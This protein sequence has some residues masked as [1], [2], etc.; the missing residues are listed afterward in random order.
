MKKAPTDK[1]MCPSGRAIPGSALLGVRQADGTVALLPQVLPVTQEFREA[2]QA[3]SDSELE[4]RFRF[5]H[6][7]AQGGCRQWASGGCKVAEVMMAHVHETKSDAP[8]PACAIRPDCRWYI[9]VG[10]EVCRVCPSVISH[11]TEDEIQKF[12]QLTTN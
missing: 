4:Q 6:K 2:A 12:N 9:Q 8:I 5:T 3:T 1:T 10:P 11:I 7:C